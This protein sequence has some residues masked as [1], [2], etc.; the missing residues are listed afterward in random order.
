MAAFGAVEAAIWLARWSPVLYDSR[1]DSLTFAWWGIALAAVYGAVAGFLAGTLLARRLGVGPTALIPLMALLLA[2]GGSRALQPVLGIPGATWTMLGVVTLVLL[3]TAALAPRRTAPLRI[4]WV[5]ASLLIVVTISVPAFLSARMALGAPT[6]PEG[7]RSVLLITIDTL[8]A[9][10]LG[11]FRGQGELPPGLEKSRTPGLDA[12]A[13]RSFAFLDTSTPI[14]KTP[15]A[16][17]SLMTGDYTYRHGFESLFSTL[18][19]SNRT[20]AE[21]FRSRG[22]VTAAVLTNG[23]IDRGSGI[24]QGFDTYQGR[25]GLRGQVKHLVLLDLLA[26]LHPR[27]VTFFLNR[28][29]TTRPQ[30]EVADV[31]TDRAI[32][33]LHAVEGRPFFLWV[34]YLDPHWTYEPPEPYRDEVDPSPRQPLTVYDEIESGK[35]TIGDVIHHNTMP[36]EEVER[37]DSLYAGEVRFLDDQVKRLVDAATDGPA[38]GR[39]VLVV[40]ADHGESLGEHGYFFSHGDRVYQQSLHIPLMFHLPGQ[41][42]GRKIDEPVSLIDVTPT[43]LDMFDIGY[44]SERDGMSL[45]AVLSPGGEHALP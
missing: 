8:R 17:S 40:T 26:R 25:L 4:S 28:F 24:S 35:L 3:A 33:M 13:S 43:L 22:W 41:T 16:I 30:S 34:H 29:D 38:G 32:E 44:A 21:E 23:L 10:A 9:D 5:A 6:P 42:D 7:A 31:T 15:Q 36:A 2:W 37:L 45:A 14:P 27:A 18:A 12:L 1:A 11:A 20:L 39:T 19:W